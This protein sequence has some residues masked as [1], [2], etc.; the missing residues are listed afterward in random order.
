M[1][2]FPK[3]NIEE[4]VVYEGKVYRI[5]SIHALNWFMHVPFVYGI[6]LAHT[7]PNEPYAHKEL[8]VREGLLQKATISQVG[9]WK[10]LYGRNR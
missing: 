3:Y 6:V 4:Y 1:D 5:T 7:R 8:H 9:I 2:I 10:T